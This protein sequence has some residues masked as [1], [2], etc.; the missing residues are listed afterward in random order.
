MRYKSV[1]FIILSR[2]KNYQAGKMKATGILLAALLGVLMSTISVNGWAFGAGRYV[3]DFYGGAKDMW[4]N[5]K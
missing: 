5:Y 4:N 3:N 2:E 1:V